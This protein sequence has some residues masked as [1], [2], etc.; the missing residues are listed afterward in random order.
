MSLGGERTKIIIGS[1]KSQL[2]LVQSEYVKSLLEK[3]YPHLTFELLTMQTKGDIVLDVALSKIGDKGLFTEELENDMREGKIDFAVHSLKDLPTELPEGLTL[4]AITEREDPADVVI[5]RKDLTYKSIAD[6]PQGSII[7]SSSL[8][9]IAQ[10]KRLYPHL[11]FKDIRGNLNTRFRKLDDPENNY[12]GMIL[13][14]AGVYRLGPEFYNRI[15]HRLNNVFYAVGQGALGIE[16]RA[17]D[18]ELKQLLQ[19]INHKETWIKCTAERAFM[20]TLQGG[21]H[22]PVGVVTTL[23]GQNVHLKGRILNLDGSQ[24]VESEKQGSISD[25]GEIGKEL[26]LECLKQGGDEILKSLPAARQK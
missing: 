23:E 11:T 18:E 5:L 24:C 14:Y 4:A 21:C 17:N 16:C 10:L 3:A 6:L 7:G 15:T 26:A 25:A 22:V 9:R 12:S 8:R 20:R 2:A 19:I 13:A 1:R